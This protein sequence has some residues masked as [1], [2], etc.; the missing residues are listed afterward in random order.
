[1]SYL[2]LMQ[3]LKKLPKEKYNLYANSIL[4]TY[5]PPNDK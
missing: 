5:T 4:Q 1:M 2:E 3:V